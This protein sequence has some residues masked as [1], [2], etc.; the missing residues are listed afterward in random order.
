M[1][2]QRVSSR[3]RGFAMTGRLVLMLAALAAFALVLFEA[4]PSVMAQTP[5]TITGNVPS[6]G[7]FALVVWGGGSTDALGSASA[8]GGCNMQSAW[9]T[10]E[11]NFAGYVPGAPAFVNTTFT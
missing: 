9:V 3:D 6:G 11:G 7:G 2:R 1:M 8:A 10:I 5:G 4:A